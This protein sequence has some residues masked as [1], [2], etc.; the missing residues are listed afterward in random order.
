MRLTSRWLF[1]L[2]AVLI[3]L[4]SLVFALPS[5]AQGDFNGTPVGLSIYRGSGYSIGYPNFWDVTNR[6]ADVFFGVGNSPVCAE[7][8]MTV[9]A[10]GAANGATADQLIDSYIAGFTRPQVDPNRLAIRQIGRSA[11]FVSPCADGSPRQYRLTIFVVY[12]QAF[13]VSQFAPQAAYPAWDS[14]YLSILES[15]APSS[16]GGSEGGSAIQLPSTSPLAAIAHIFGGNVYVGTLVD[17]PGRPVTQGATEARPYRDPS[18][19]PDGKWLAFID[20]N[21]RAIYVTPLTG[22]EL[23]KIAEFITLGYPIAWS[24]NAQEIAYLA[25]VDGKLNALAVNLDGSRERTLGVTQAAPD[26]CNQSPRDRLEAQLWEEA[27]IRAERPLL[28]W[29]DEK[30][31]LYSIQCGMGIAQ[32][33]DGKDS[34][35]AMGLAGAQLSPDNT[36]LFGYQDLE[37]LPM[38]TRYDLTKQEIVTLR[39]DLPAYQIAWSPDGKAIYYAT[40]TEKQGITLDSEA[41]KARIESFFGSFPYATVVNEVSLR[42]RELESGVEVE[43]YKADAYQIGRILPAPDGSG[44][45]FSVVQ[46]A[47]AQIEAF[48]NNVSVG[49]LR[50]VAPITQLYWIGI[51]NRVATPAQWIAVSHAA[52]WGTLGSAEAPTPTAGPRQPG[53]PTPD[54]RLLT[55]TPTLSVTPTATATAAPTNSPTPSSGR[56]ALPTNTPRPT[57]TQTPIG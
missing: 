10:M 53:D 44:V 22:G 43:L 1:L 30:T 24:P 36:Q 28:A 47:A 9:A 4:S 41:D 8:G 17:L 45:L 5:G 13:R 20:P 40:Y 51:S 48:N 7:P 25:N 39:T 57:R 55:R 21:E 52:V 42:R 38:S 12:G 15:F 29:V 34:I 18:I 50:R 14:V 23:R 16:V 27:G 11:L 2:S 26:G 49:E 35:I 31:L 6:G 32:L 3:A 37:G 54:L 46:S 56:L 19:S 33:Q